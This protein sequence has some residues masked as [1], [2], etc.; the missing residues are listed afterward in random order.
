VESEVEEGVAQLEAQLALM[1]GEDQVN[2]CIK[3]LR[4]Q[5]ATS[6][7][8]KAEISYLADTQTQQKIEGDSVQNQ[9]RKAVSQATRGKAQIN[10]LHQ[11][12]KELQRQKE[13]KSEESNT[14]RRNNLELT[15]K[16]E[17]SLT[18]I[19]DQLNKHSDDRLAQAEENIKLRDQLREVAKY[20]EIRDEHY[21]KLLKTKDLE[22]QIAEAKLQEVTQSSLAKVASSEMELTRLRVSE[23]ELRAQLSEYST[24]FE[25][26]QETLKKSNELFTTFKTEMDKMSKQVKKVQKEKLEI[27]IK[28]KD[29]QLA[30]IKMLGERKQTKEQLDKVNR[31]K[32]KLAELMKFREVEFKKVKASCTCE[33]R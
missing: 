19:S 22:R 4:E 11:L 31:Q 7:R 28:H 33:A 15:T 26:V 30:L 27:E 2:H 17:T 20:N 8:R 18:S 21:A 3:V 29:S 13:I 1:S 14:H 10:Q 6:L 23:K 24:K 16:F 9:L 32:D 12:C 25:Q 5:H